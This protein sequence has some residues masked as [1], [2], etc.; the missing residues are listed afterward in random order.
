MEYSRE[1]SLP[2]NTGARCRYCHGDHNKETILCDREA[3]LRLR[4][5]EALEDIAEYLRSLFESH[6]G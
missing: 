1:G 4:A 6:V 3:Y 2:E 5:V